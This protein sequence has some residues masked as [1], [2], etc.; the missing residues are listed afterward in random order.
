MKEGSF[1]LAGIITD[2]VLLAVL[3]GI[4]SICI[5][6]VTPDNGNNLRMLKM[7]NIERFILFTRELLFMKIFIVS[8]LLFV[9]VSL[10]L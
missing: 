2:R 5:L 9:S 7:L 4:L 10:F 8:R 1:Q 3:N 6:I